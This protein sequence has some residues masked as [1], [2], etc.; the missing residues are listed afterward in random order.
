MYKKFEYSMHDTGL[1]AHGNNQARPCTSHVL[2]TKSKGTTSM[3][4][5]GNN[6]KAFGLSH[7]V[8]H[9]HGELC[10]LKNVIF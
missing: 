7:E 6:D 4:K 5:P 8:V 10:V 9:K 2:S 1:G 3:Q